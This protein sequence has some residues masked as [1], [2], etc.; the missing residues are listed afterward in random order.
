MHGEVCARCCLSRGIWQM[1][2]WHEWKCL[3][4]SRD[5]DE[6]RMGSSVDVWSHLDL[7]SSLL[8]AKEEV[9]RWTL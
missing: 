3:P 6:T 9:T 7:R 5:E 8:W 4:P 2:I 1:A